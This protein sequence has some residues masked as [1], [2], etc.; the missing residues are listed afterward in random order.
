MKI[1]EKLYELMQNIEEL[2]DHRQ[3]FVKSVND[4]YQ[5][6]GYMTEAQEEYIDFY[7]EELAREI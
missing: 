1:E 4:F 2:D 5:R 6:R 3:N 7:Y